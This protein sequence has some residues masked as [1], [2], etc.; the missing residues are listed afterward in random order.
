MFDRLL[1]D[2]E[3]DN[4]TPYERTKVGRHATQMLGEIGKL[5]GETQEISEERLLRLPAWRRIQETILLALRPW[6]EAA[7]AVG[8]ALEGLGR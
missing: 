1:V 4:I 2:L 5:T 7:R 8:K 6:P 3:S